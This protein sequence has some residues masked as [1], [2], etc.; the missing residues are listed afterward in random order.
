MGKEKRV[1]RGSKLGVKIKI[2]QDDLPKKYKIFPL[3]ET[4]DGVQSSVYLLGDKYVLKLYDEPNYNIEDEILLLKSISSLKVIQYVEDFCIR[5]Y[6]CIFYKQIKGE[7]IFKPTISHIKQIAL[8]LREFHTK[9]SNNV[10]NNTNL[11]D[12]NELK[13][14]I[15]KRGI[16][17]L[18]KHI[19]TINI[20]LK[21]DGIIHGDLFCD[22]VKWENDILS[23]VYDFSEACNG[24][25][26][27]DLAV[28]ACS[29][30]F[31]DDEPN[32]EKIDALLCTYALDIKLVEFKEYIKYALI[33]YATK[34]YLDNRNYQ[35]LISKLDKVI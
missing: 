5:G 17:L 32:Y 1:T 6:I 31:D 14:V 11:Y 26:I 9:T 25:F 3:I 4:T 13:S 12:T 34:R 2:T 20:K 35:E 8:F 21:N 28:V 18:Q 33:Y 16:T 30:C 27:F 10:S 7:S 22:N 29:W 15:N 23:G 24:D 19:N